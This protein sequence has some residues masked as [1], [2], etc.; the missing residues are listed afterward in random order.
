MGVALNKLTAKTFFALG[1]VMVTAIVGSVGFASADHRGG[2]NGGRGEGNGSVLGERDD[3]D[4]YGGNAGQIQAAV[5]KFQAAVAAAQTKL[6]T[7]IQ[8]C[9]D[10]HVAS[11]NTSTR[12]FEDR[13]RSAG[14]PLRSTAANPSFTSLAPTQADDKLEDSERRVSTTLEDS[15]GNFDR[16]LERERTRTDRNALGRCLR[17]ANRTFLDSVKDAR[18]ELLQTLRNI[19]RRH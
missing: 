9:V 8:A 13:N 16:T 7:D 4:G 18:Q 11:V 6:N 3:R 19:T 12:D 5:A 14:N 1:V 2:N 15:V 17:T 10:A